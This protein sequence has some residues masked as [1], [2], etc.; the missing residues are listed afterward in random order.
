MR[1]A[2]EL[3]DSVKQMALPHVVQRGLKRTDRKGKEEG[4]LLFL[5]SVCLLSWDIHVIPHPWTGIDN[6]GSLVPWPSD[7]A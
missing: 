6:T 2:F 7:S 5:P 3:V 4:I 1:L